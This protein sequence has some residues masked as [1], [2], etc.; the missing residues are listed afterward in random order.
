MATAA[1]DRE[2][3]EAVVAEMAAGIDCA[4][5]FW[6]AQIDA[7]YENNH[8][9]TLGRLQAIREI[10]RNYRLTKNDGKTA[11]HGYAA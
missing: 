10:L 9:T 7:V 2:L 1:A 6:M 5:E 4:V 11:D 3:I 8:I